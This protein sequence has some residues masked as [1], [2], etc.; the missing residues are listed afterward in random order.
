MRFAGIDIGSRT[1]HESI[2][3]AGEDVSPR[4]SA[5]AIIAGIDVGSR[6][7]KTV[8]LKQYQILSSAVMD[9]GV[10]PRQTAESA[11]AQAAAEAGIGRKQIQCVVGTGYGRVSLSFVDKTVTELTCHARGCHFINPQVRTVIDIGGQDSKVIR[12]NDNGDMV[13]FVMNDK[14]AAGTGKFLE[15][16]ARTLGLSLEEMSA[17]KIDPKQACAI[18][19]MCVVFAETEIISLLAKRKAPQAIVAGIHRAYATRIGNMA[20]RLG[21]LR[22]TVFVGGV[23]KNTGLANAL[24][25]YLDSPFTRLPIDPQLAGALGAAVLAQQI[26]AG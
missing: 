3:L 20:K 26:V 21:L 16:A 12:L 2:P 23:A 13:D 11:L 18:N 5:G 22:P 25:H 1:I 10:N 17:V 9:S 8:I 19:S 7:T 14:C 6:T 15:M 24:A 4:C